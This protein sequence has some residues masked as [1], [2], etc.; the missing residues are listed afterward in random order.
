VFFTLPSMVL[1]PKAHAAGIAFLNVVGIAGTAVTPMIMGT[2]TDLTGTFVAAMIAMGLVL[3][4]GGSSMFL[5]PRRILAGEEA[6]AA[7]APAS[8]AGQ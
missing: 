5:V 2:M 1:P 6:A 7:V 8:A 4:L 3:V